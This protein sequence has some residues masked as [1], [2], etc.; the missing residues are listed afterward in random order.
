VLFAVLALGV[1]YGAGYFRRTQRGPASRR[2]QALLGFHLAIVLTNAFESLP[3]SS[4]ALHG[5]SLGCI[6]LAVILLIAPAAYHRVVCA[7]EDKEEV[8][9]VG[10]WFITAATVP[11]ALGLTGDVH[12][13][14]ARIADSHALGA[15]AAGTSLVLLILLWHVLPMAL[16]ARR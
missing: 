7:G 10:S 3:A 13:V 14:I 6:A 11:L 12:V 9:R 8:H 5:I 2:A 16:R 15:A 1:W 4:K